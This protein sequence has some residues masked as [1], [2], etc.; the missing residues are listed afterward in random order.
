MGLFIG[1]LVRGATGLWFTMFSIFLIFSV[2]AY[3]DHFEH[4][5]IKDSLPSFHFY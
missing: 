3:G 5:D 2:L 1:D 4:M